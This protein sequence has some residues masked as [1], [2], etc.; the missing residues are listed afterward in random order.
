MLCWRAAS[1]YALNMKIFK[2]QKR[3]VN[4]PVLYKKNLF[5]FAGF[6]FLT[7]FVCLIKIISLRENCENLKNSLLKGCCGNLSYFH[8]CLCCCSG[9]E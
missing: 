4:I 8:G 2:A 9:I 3:E 1:S 5:L 6:I 7:S